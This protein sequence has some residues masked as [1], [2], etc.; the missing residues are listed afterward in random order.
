M[1]EDLGLTTRARRAEGFVAEL[2][3]FERCLFEAN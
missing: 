1:A 3:Q 2:T